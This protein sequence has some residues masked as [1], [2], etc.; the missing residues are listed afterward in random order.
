M[1]QENDVI[2]QYSNGYIINN[3]TILEVPNQYIA[4]A[5]VDGKMKFRQGPGEYLI[6][7]I[8]KDFLK[9]KLYLVLFGDL[10]ISTLI[11]NV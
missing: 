2:V 7:K 9:S 5:Y 4:I 8:N 11:M 6:Y 3:D 10:V 1:N